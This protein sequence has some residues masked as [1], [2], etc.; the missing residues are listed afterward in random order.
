MQLMGDSATTVGEDEGE[1]EA[2]KRL[3]TAVHE[4]ETKKKLKVQK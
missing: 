3:R 1:S 4:E 2:A